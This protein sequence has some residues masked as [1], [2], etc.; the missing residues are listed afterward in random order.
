MP[1][2]VKLNEIVGALE[3][4]YD[5][6]P[7]YVNLDTGEV[8]TIARELLDLDQRPGAEDVVPPSQKAELAVARSIA[9]GGP[10]HRIPSNHD[11]HEWK[12]ME[13]FAHSMRSEALREDLLDAIHGAG[14]FRNFKREI[15]RHAMDDAW[16]QFRTDALRQIAIEWCEGLGLAWK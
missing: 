1:V 16:F 9:G 6:R 2:K 8:H 4:Q 14:A 3:M 7:S 15:K 10:F 5:E 13:E 12:I 11:I